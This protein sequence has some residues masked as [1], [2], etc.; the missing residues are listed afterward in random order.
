MCL[1]V[2]CESGFI[3]ESKDGRAQVLGLL[4]ALPI[5]LVLIETQKNFYRKKLGF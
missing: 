2:G 3:E 5:V 1:V 4:L